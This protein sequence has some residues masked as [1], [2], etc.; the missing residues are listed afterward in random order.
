MTESLLAGDSSPLYTRSMRAMNPRHVLQGILAVFVL[1]AALTTSG[2]FHRVRSLTDA[3]NGSLVV[4]D[5]GDV[6]RIRLPGNASTGY[7]WERIDPAELA[8]TPL[9]AIE[10]GDYRSDGTAPGSPGVFTFRYAAAARGTFT[11]TLAYHRPW[12]DEPPLETYA[13]IVWVP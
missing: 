12:E 13:V 11:L 4:M 1:A 9:E 7:L 2:C 3:D 8:G 6:L 5:V 10:E